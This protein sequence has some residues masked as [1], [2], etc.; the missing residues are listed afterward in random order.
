M[1]V[2]VVFGNID[3][4]NNSQLNLGKAHLVGRINAAPTTQI[5]LQPN[6]QWS[7]NGN[8]TV[9]N[10]ELLPNSQITLNANYDD[11]NKNYRGWIQFNELTINGKLTGN[12]HFR[13]LT[14]V[15]ERRGDHITVNGLASGS[16]ILSVKNTGK[17]PNEVNL[18][19]LVKLNH[20]NQRIGQARFALENG[21]VDLGAY[22][23]IL[24]NRNNDYRLYN[25]LR[26]AEQSFQGSE[27]LIANSQREFEKVHQL[28]NQK[29]QELNRLNAQY[30]DVKAKE[31]TYKSHVARLL[32]DINQT[33]NQI[34]NA[35]NEYNRTP[36]I[37]FIKRRRLYEQFTQYKS[38]LENQRNEYRNINSQVNYYSQ[39]VSSVLGSV[40]AI[41]NEVN[42]L[43]SQQGNLQAELNRLQ[44]GYA[45]K[46][47]QAQKL[48]TAQGLSSDVCRKVA[49]SR[50]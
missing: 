33:N 28:L 32:S 22:R 25:P 1:P 49:K 27:Q 47:A 23:Y 29:Q 12:G 26:E 7:L 18:L 6:S 8:S 35:F 40:N 44:A 46:L 9:G 20:P 15:A 41:K 30:E 37:R 21:Y 38:K 3:L 13:F 45:N 16:Y 11:V 4:K 10:L 36:R 5:Y 2:T 39:Q 34:D 24:A 19:S 17:E 43:S 31:N 14:N 42:S 48:C 50:K